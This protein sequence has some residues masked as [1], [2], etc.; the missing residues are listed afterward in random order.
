MRGVSLI[1]FSD[2]LRFT[3][4]NLDLQRFQLAKR[5]CSQDEKKVGGCLDVP[6]TN[7]KEMHD[8]RRLEY[9]SANE[10]C[11]TEVHSETRKVI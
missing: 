8:L 1:A 7:E 5:I 4:T 9:S 2:I 3:Y 6:S 11:I 10:D